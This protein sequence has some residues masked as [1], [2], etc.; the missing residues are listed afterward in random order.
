M[1]KILKYEM[2]ILTSYLDL[3]SRKLLNHQFEYEE[4]YIAGFVSRFIKGE[5][6]DKE[7]IAFT[8]EE[9]SIIESLIFH[10]IDNNDGKDLLSA[11]LLTKIVCNIMNKYKNYKMVFN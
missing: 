7:F 8:K 1:K 10:N 5:R 6:F 9:I 4:D 3:P 2:K 11:F